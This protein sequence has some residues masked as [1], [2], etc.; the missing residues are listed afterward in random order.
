MP[1]KNERDY[2]KYG[3]NYTQKIIKEKWN[4]KEKKKML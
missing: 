3:L 2:S 4:A 1:E